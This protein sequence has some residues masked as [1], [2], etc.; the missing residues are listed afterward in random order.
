MMQTQ[1]KFVVIT[2]TTILALCLVVAGFVATI[3]PYWL[4]RTEVKWRQN[5][6][7]ENKIRFVKPLQVVAQ[8]PKLVLL[9]SSIVYRGLDP[10]DAVE[11][12]TYNFGVSSLRIREAE[13]YV[14]EVLRWTQTREIVLGVDYFAFDK[15]TPHETGF[16]ANAADG[17][18]LIQSFGAAFLSKTALM[19]AWSLAQGTVVDTEGRWNQNGYKETHPRDESYIAHQLKSTREFFSKT[20]ISPD[21]LDAL[22]RIIVAT[23][24]AHV[25][26]K[27]FLPPYHGTWMDATDESV[28][29]GLTFDEWVDAVARLARQY[30]IELWD[31]ANANPTS[32]AP[33]GKGSEY[34]LDASHFSP[35]VGRWILSRLNVGPRVDVPE[36]FGRK[37]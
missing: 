20:E 32:R 14:R 21:E 25:E 36:G 18:Y 6:P 11:P 22:E 27:L 30:D 8:Q 37:L 34:Y 29:A 12:R 15:L 4:W 24:R 7:F 31:F 5:V 26:L 13:V 3:D 10:S 19:D 33:M 35:T 17:D 23:K 9:G 16:D 2:V 28:Q 1:R